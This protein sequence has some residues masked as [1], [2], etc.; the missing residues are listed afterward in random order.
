MADGDGFVH[1]VAVNPPRLDARDL[2][3]FFHAGEDEVL[4]LRGVSLAAERGELVAVQGPSGSGKSTLLACIAG[5]DQPDGGRV[6][7]DGVAITHRSE[8]ERAGIRARS[9]GVVFQSDNLIGHLTLEGNVTLA[10]R[11]AGRTDPARLRVLL[12]A[13]GLGD[14]AGAYPAQLSGGEA[15]RAALAVG[16]ANDPSV[17]VADE[18]TGE[19]DSGTERQV[20]DL[21][22]DHAAAGAAIV[23]ATHS[24]GVAT[25]ADR[26]VRLVD[27]AVA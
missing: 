16:L 3:R 15:V 21:L 26:V 20:L 8:A 1:L 23:V 9:I 17:I 24:D 2:Y 25:A 19:L 12:E 14:R 13:L 6:R 22:H 4:A 18:P 27:G 7:I 11:L 10:Q 5:L